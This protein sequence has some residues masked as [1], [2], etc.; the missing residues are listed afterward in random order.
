MIP[1]E[2]QFEHMQARVMFG[3][4]DLVLSWMEEMPMPQSLPDDILNSLQ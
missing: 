1:F 2:A 4:N 3:M